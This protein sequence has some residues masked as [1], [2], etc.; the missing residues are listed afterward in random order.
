[1]LRNNQ[2]APRGVQ[3]DL[4]VQFLKKA[5]F[6]KLAGGSVRLFVLRQSVFATVQRRI[7]LLF[8]R[9]LSI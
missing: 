4:T 5:D 1:M 6:L 3:Y 8:E 7:F 9:S 2:R